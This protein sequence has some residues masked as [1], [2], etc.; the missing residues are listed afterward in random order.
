MLIHHNTK[1][2]SL[3][4]YRI[5]EQ[6]E[7][8]LRVAGDVEFAVAE[9]PER[10]R[11]LDQPD[12]ADRRCPRV[13][14]PADVPP[15]LSLAEDLRHPVQVA[16]DHPVDLLP[17]VRPSAGNPFREEDPGTRV[18]LPDRLD[19]EPEDP[20]QALQRVL[21][22]GARLENVFEETVPHPP[23]R[24][25][26]DLLFPLEVTV[27]RGGDDPDPSGD[28]TNAQPLDPLAAAA[29]APPRRSAPSGPP[30]NEGGCQA[31]R[32]LPFGSSHAGSSKSPR[33]ILAAMSPWSASV[34]G[35]ETTWRTTMSV[36]AFT[37]RAILRG[38]TTR[39]PSLTWRRFS[40][41]TTSPSPDRM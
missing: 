37:P 27:D 9:I 12:E 6:S 7:R 39:S 21:L 40:P 3:R 34:G 1:I 24:G 23:D 30:D 4:P 22:R 17:M 25:G 5:R 36:F 38:T 28:R 32:I 35:G 26:E 14:I 11:R 16:A 33:A 10:G 15:L 8:P 18:S 31:P 19:V 29:Q 2:T 13:D 41:A 20:P